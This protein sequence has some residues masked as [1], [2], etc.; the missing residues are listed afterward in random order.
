MLRTF[1]ERGALASG[2]LFVGGE[3]GLDFWGVDE[4]VG[5][6]VWS[7]LLDFGQSEGPAFGRAFDLS[8]SFCSSVGRW[9]N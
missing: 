6:H 8:G 9:G 7:P 2:C 4:D 3:V 1:C 5:L